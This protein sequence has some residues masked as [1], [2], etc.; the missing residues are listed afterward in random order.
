MD[1]EVIK[2][3][4]LIFGSFFSFL[5]GELAKIEKWNLKENFFY[6]HRNLTN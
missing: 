3:T 6:H 2:G 4:W 1:V 5:F